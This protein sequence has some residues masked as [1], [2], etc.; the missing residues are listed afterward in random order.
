MPVA[1]LIVSVI[2]ALFTLNAYRP[3]LKAGPF[4]V[5]T[6]FAGWLTSELPVHHVVW[7]AVASAVFIWRG[8]LHEWQG[9]LG[10]GITAVSWVG[11]GYLAQEAHRAGDVAELALVE[12]LGPAYPDRLDPPLLDRIG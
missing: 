9:W 4:S 8:A 2:G 5:P 7:Q 11:L 6:F 12:T 10:L 1:F 3:L